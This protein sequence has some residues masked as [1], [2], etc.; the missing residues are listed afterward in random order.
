M[1]REQKI[2]KNDILHDHRHFECENRLPSPMTLAAILFKIPLNSLY[3]TKINLKWSEMVRGPNSKKN[4][5]LHDH[6]HLESE[7]QSSAP[8][9]RAAILFYAKNRH[10]PCTS[11]RV[12]PAHFFCY[13][14]K[15]SFQVRNF[16]GHNLVTGLKQFTQLCKARWCGYK[17]AAEFGK[18]NYYHISVRT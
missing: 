13:G 5:V 9:A 14:L 8:V 17:G 16:P 2:T 7:N 11:Q 1:V 10:F 18:G 6:M 3:G 12:I 4:D 15:Y